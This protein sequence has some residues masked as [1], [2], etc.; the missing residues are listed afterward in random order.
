MRQF[1]AKVR[2]MQSPLAR[3]G[4][5]L[6]FRHLHDEATNQMHSP[7]A[8]RLSGQDLNRL[9]FVDEVGKMPPVWNNPMD[10]PVWNLQEIVDIKPNHKPTHGFID[11]FAYFGVQCLRQ[12]FD[13]FAGFKFGQ[14]TDQKYIRRVIFLETIAGVPGMVAGMLR[15]MTSLRR[16]R[17]DHGWIHTL[18]E[19]AENERMHLLT[20]LEIK[21]PSLPMRVAIL[22]SQG[23]FFN[24]FFIAYICSPKLCH[25]FVGYVEEEAVKTYTHL[26]KD[27]DDGKVFKGVGCP[28]LAISYWRLPKDAKFRELIL[29]IRADEAGHRLVNH[30]FADMHA[31]GLQYKTNPFIASQGVYGQ[32]PSSQGGQPPQAAP[33]NQQKG[34]QPTTAHKTSE[35][36]PKE[37]KK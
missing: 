20:F 30:T 26:L 35:S 9:T 37:T 21:K 2:P 6:A 17:R 24:V 5:G 4:T 23:I 15:H 33:T 8:G 34:Q 11:S 7:H 14:I 28:P 13:L 32:Q 31:K 22:I 3:W 29:A 25:R 27:I 12:T 19:E 16:M 1:S 18:L 36:S 10:H